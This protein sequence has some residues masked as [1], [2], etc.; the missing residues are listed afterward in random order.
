MDVQLRSKDAVND[1]LDEV[2]ESENNKAVV[3]NL[4]ACA[5]YAYLRLHHYTEALQCANAALAEAPDHAP[6]L[7]LRA[8]VRF[9]HKDCKEPEQARVDIEEALSLRPGREEYESL[10][11]RIE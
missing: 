4:L 5:T 9:L 6:S 11:K 10:K 3:V 8:L 1:P 7:M 2:L